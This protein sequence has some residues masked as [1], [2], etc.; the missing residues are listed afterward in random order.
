MTDQQQAAL[1]LLRSCKLPSG[2]YFGM[3]CRML[4]RKLGTSPEGASRT[5]SSLVRKGLAI[6]FTGGVGK[7]RVHY[8]AVAQ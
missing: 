4:A 1:D 8:Q 2:S 7:Q 6:R 5:A 3:D